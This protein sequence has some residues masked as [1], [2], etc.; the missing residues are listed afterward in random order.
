MNL[1]LHRVDSLICTPEK[2]QWSS[3]T[4]K[5]HN[6]SWSQCIRPGKQIR[7][8][9]C[10]RQVY[11]TKSCQRGRVNQPFILFIHHIGGETVPWALFLSYRPGTECSIS[12]FCNTNCTHSIFWTIEACVGFDWAKP[13]KK[14][15]KSS[16]RRAGSHFCSASCSECLNEHTRV[17]LQHNKEII[18]FIFYLMSL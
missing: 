12:Q 2:K 6:G 8:K 17:K 4:F 9:F 13:L 1:I 5:S 16:V 18:M 7:P 10:V 14:F 15:P 3:I 11:F